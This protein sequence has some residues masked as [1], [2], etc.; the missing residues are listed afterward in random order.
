MV[1]FP[2][3]FNDEI[4]YVRVKMPGLKKAVSSVGLIIS[5]LE[6]PL[7]IKNPRRSGDYRL[8][9]FLAEATCE[10]TCMR[11]LATSAPDWAR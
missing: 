4:N 1:T 11:V 8:S 2:F 5:R 7:T 6:S 9:Y 3:A 10:I